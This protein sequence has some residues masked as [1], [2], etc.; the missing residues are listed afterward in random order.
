M[1]LVTGASGHLGKAVIR[2]LVNLYPANLIFALVRD[3]NKIDEL[4]SLGIQV[5]I[6]DYNN[7]ES[8]NLAM[9]GIKKVLLISGTDEENRV[10]QHLNVIN[11]A[12][13]ADVRFI[14]YTSRFVKDNNISHNHLMDGHFKTEAHIIDSGLEYLIFRNALYFDTIPTFVGGD[15]VF[16]IGNISVPAG[17]GKV[18]FVLRAELGEA[19]AKMLVSDKPNRE[20]IS[21]TANISWS[22]HDIAKILSEVS[23][24]PVTYTPIERSEFISRMLNLGLPELLA[25]RY[26]DFQ[27]EIKQGLLEDTTT[28][29]ERILG[30]KPVQLKEGI[31]VV[32]NV[33]Q[34]PKSED[35]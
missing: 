13:N 3:N 31:K 15:R 16:T 20:I 18:S 10:T 22:L 9:E 14:A 27:E 2:N 5:R 11:A 32:F 1:I 35:F 19:I 34:H 12:K 7:V 4:M 30:R 6:G 24:Q 25:N 26:A 17:N 21:L 23:G 29:L 8:L 28:S 33:T